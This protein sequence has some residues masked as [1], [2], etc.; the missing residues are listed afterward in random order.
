MK[1]KEKTEAERKIYVVVGRTGEYSDRSEWPV[2]WRESL[3]DADAFVAKLE[4]EAVAF[5]KWE[6]ENPGEYMDADRR[7]SAMTDPMFAC[8]YTGTTYYVWTVE[9]DPARLA[10]TEAP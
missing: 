1:A 5:K 10:A 4:A 7:K 3:A 9:R 6:D 8:D 2:C